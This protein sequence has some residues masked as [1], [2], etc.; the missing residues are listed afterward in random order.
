M[1]NNFFGTPLIASQ[2]G[3][4]LDRLNWL[5]HLLMLVLFVGWLAYFLYV[6]VRFRKSKNPQASH[7]AST[8]ATPTST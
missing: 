1:N 5:I 3:A 7:T 6:L 2:H 8:T 4:A